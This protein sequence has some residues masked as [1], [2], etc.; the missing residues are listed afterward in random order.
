[1]K[2]RSDVEIGTSNQLVYRSRID[3]GIWPKFKVTHSLAGSL[4]Q[5]M[6]VVEESARVEADSNMRFR[7]ANVAKGSALYAGGRAA[8]M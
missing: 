1:M 5:R 2:P 8:I 7:D 6:W 4:K 3:I